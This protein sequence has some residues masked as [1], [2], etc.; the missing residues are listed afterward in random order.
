MTKPIRRHSPAIMAGLLSCLALGAAGCGGAVAFQGQQAF[1]VTGNS[2]PPPPAAPVAPPARAK[3]AVAGNKITIEDK[4]QFAHDQAVILEAS[5]GL[6]NEVVKVIQTNPQIKKIL[7]EGH[8]SSEGDKAHNLKLSADR[9]K[10]V[11]D[12]LVQHGIA[13]DKLSSKGFGSSDPIADNKTEEGR[14]KNR[15]VEFTIVDPPSAGGAQK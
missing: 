15:R 12:Y 7:V 5:F 8:A 10:A 9:A 6:L 3:V 14:E 4:V 1:S 2:V 11:M 13:Q